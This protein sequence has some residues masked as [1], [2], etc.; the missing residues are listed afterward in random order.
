MRDFVV[1]SAEIYKIVKN[2]YK[3]SDERS[4]SYKS[5]LIAYAVDQ[6]LKIRRTPP[7]IL[8]HLFLFDVKTHHLWTLEN[9]RQIQVCLWKEF[10]FFS[11]AIL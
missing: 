8:R 3:Y 5:E 2:M 9:L 11:L 10:F 4:E 1:V 7:V 6:L